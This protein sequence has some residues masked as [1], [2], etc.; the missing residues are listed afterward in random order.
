MKRLELIGVEGMGE[1]EPGDSV[2]RLICEACARER[3]DIQDDDVLVVAQKIVSKSEGRIVGLGTV[4]PSA[5]ARELGRQLGKEPEL[6]EV[7]LGESRRI[8]RSGGRALI[9][10]THH[11]FVCAN[12]GVDQSNVGLK[13][14]ALLPEDADR[15]AR[16]IR[17]EIRRRLN[18]NPGIVISDSF[19]RPWRLGTVDV[20]VGI[21]GIVP[22]KDE[23]GA[24]DR[25]GYQL[26]AAVTAV[27][28]EIAAAAELAMGKRDGIPV[29]IVRGYQIEK[30]EEG[31]V[32]ELLRPATED[33]FR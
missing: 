30:K 13:Q 3:I 23:R 31:S 9:V 12:A 19:G 5:R 27:A 28:D 8:V 24:H 10:E 15:S 6:V 21:A 22:F 2:G 25:H 1:V 7:I 20:A 14:A 33:L 26:K 17:A 4:E 32:R 18:K 29:V 16:A 11:G